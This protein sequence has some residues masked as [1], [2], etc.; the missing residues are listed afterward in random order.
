[1]KKFESGDKN[2]ETGMVSCSISGHLITHLYWEFEAL[3]NAM[4]AALDVLSRLCGLE[5]S[6]QT[7][8]SLNNFSKKKDLMGTAAIFREERGKWID[9]M[10]DLRD[11]FVHYTPIDSIPYLTF[12]RT[13]KKWK[14]YAKLPVNPNVRIADQFKFS[15]RL[16]VLKYSLELFAKFVDL[17]D[18]VAKYL[19]ALHGNGQFPKRKDNLFNLGQRT[20]S[21]K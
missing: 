16:D 18:R 9:Q 3:L 7:P 5:F 12:Y 21:V 14:V 20:R 10:K 8:I 19:D 15:R 6:E 13:P 4:S 2:N 11:C 1:V 17:D